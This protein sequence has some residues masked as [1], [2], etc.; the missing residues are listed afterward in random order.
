MN[1]QGHSDVVTSVAVSPDSRFAASA[2]SDKTVRVWR[3]PF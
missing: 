1:L 3:L 2:S